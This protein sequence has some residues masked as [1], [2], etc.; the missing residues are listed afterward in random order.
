MIQRCSSAVYLALVLM[1][2]MSGL[3]F[4]QTVVPLFNWISPPKSLTC[5]YWYGQVE[6]GTNT[7]SCAV[8][9]AASEF[10]RNEAVLRALA[11][12]PGT[13]CTYPAQAGNNR[14]GSA[15]YQ[16]IERHTD[17]DLTDFSAVNGCVLAVY[18][19]LVDHIVGYSGNSPLFCFGSNPRI[20]VSSP[21]ALGQPNSIVLSIDPSFINLP[22]AV[23]EPGSR[24]LIGQ[25]HNYYYVCVDGVAI[26]VQLFAVFFVPG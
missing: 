13:N 23:Y 20:H 16:R 8:C 15:T 1:C 7:T 24:A 4:S 6:P 2:A 19:A 18:T 14:C 3:A 22:C 21:L 26:L 9:D 17:A 10:A 25:S 5:L 12:A 11:S